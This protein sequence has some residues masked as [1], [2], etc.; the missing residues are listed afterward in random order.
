MQNS[1]TGGPLFSAS[2]LVNFLGCTHATVL[3]LANLVRPQQFPD[4]DDQTKLLQELGIAHERNYLASLK[5]EGRLV[6]EIPDIGGLVERVRLTLDAMRSGADVIY[7][8]RCTRAN[9]MAIRT[10][11]SKWTGF[12]QSSATMPM[13]LPTPSCR[14]RQNPSISFSFASM[15]ICWPVFRELTRPISMLSSAMVTLPVSKLRPCGI[16]T[17]PRE[18]ALSL[19]SARTM[20]VRWR[21]PVAIAPI[22]GG[23]THVMVD[24]SAAIT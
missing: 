12:H 17:Q 11:C 9:G 21:N 6:A 10:F 20:D 7:Q 19:M 23:T 14:A 15:P 5:G 22:A 13:T 1:Q 3:D 16:I 4:D 2:D 18:I 8:G 24:G